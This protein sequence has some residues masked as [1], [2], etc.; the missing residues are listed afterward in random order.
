MPSPKYTDKVKQLQKNKERELP[1]KTKSI[2]SEGEM[3]VMEAA[4]MKK[5]AEKMA[6]MPKEPSELEKQRAITE[7][8]RQKGIKSW[9]NLS[10]EEQLRRLNLW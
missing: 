7:M 3:K 10:E 6:D 8:I 5:M 2:S 4:P 9:E 1:F